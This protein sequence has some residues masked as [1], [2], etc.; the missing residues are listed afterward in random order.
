VSETTTKTQQQQKLSKTPFFLMALMAAVDAERRPLA[1]GKQ[2]GH[3]SQRQKLQQFFRSKKLSISIGFLPD[4]FHHFNKMHD[5]FQQ[6]HHSI[7]SEDCSSGIFL[8]P[9]GPS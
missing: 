4:S 5:N 8:G 2:I 3:K 7:H 6:H 9:R 1:I